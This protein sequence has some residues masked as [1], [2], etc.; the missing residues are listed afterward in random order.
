MQVA[1]VLNHLLSR[2]HRRKIDIR[3]HLR[4]RNAPEQRQIVLVARALQ[5]AHRPEGIAARKTERAERVRIGE[6]F[7]YRRRQPRAQPEIAH[8]IEAAPA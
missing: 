1:I 5:R 8:R 7:E 6:A 2:R 4:H 3:L